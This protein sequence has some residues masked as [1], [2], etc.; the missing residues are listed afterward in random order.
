MSKIYRYQLHHN[1]EDNKTKI[2]I[3]SMDIAK[4]TAKTISYHITDRNIC[5]TIRK[6]SLGKLRT[7]DVMLSLSPNDLET[8]KGLI[9]DKYESKRQTLVKELGRTNRILMNIDYKDYE[10]VNSER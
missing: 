6:D 5:K 3:I 4:E 8:F 7:C 10:I 1:D 9:N 2:T